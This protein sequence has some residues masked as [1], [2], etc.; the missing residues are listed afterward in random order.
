MSPG[1]QEVL[2]IVIFI[3]LIFIVGSWMNNY[4][5]LAD[6]MESEEKRKENFAKACKF[7]FGAILVIG[8]IAYIFE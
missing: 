1:T 2:G 8:G 5:P 3:I 4:G 7:G 6:D